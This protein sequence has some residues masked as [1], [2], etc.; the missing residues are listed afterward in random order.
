MKQKGETEF[1]K[2]QTQYIDEFKPKNVIVGGD[3]E[4]LSHT[5]KLDVEIMKKNVGISDRKHEREIVNYEHCHIFHSY[6][7]HGRKQFRTNFVGGHYH[8]VKVWTDEQGNWCSECSEPKQQN[9]SE[10]IVAEDLH[11]HRVVYIRSGVIKTNRFNPQA[12][13]LIDRIWREPNAPAGAI[14]R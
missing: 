12:Q 9:G 1:P 3:V 7:G 10:K 4:I 2:V 5:F 8:E 11:T 14:S 13:A 6:D